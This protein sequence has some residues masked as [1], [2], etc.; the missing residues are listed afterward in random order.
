M[1]VSPN[2][3]GG[4]VLAELHMLQQTNRLSGWSLR[5]SPSERPTVICS[6]PIRRWHQ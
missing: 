5:L 4:W 1:V 6:Q 2:V 3:M